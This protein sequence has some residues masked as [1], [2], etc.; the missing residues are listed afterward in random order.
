MIPA[1][2]LA[3][4]RKINSGLVSV[5]E[6]LSYVQDDCYMTKSSAARYIDHDK[7]K[8][9][10]AIRTGKLRAFRCGKKCLVK[11]SDIDAWIEAGEITRAN[12]QA[13]KNGLQQLTDLALERARANVAA[14]KK[15]GTA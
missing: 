11:K 10:E 15:A 7:R 13:D 6:I 8:I 3:T 4:A 1:E 2:D 9:E 5:A 12:T 14:R